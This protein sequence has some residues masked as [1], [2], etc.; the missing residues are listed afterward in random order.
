[1]CPAAADDDTTVVVAVTVAVAAYVADGP[2][3]DV[4]PQVGAAVV[5]DSGVGA[6]LAPTLALKDEE[7]EE[8]DAMGVGR[9]V[10]AIGAVRAAVVRVWLAVT[11]MAVPK[12]T[13]HTL[14]CST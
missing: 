4:V 1:M 9:V 14:A 10:G 5:R 6:A 2:V 11:S 7:E 3:R 12:R 8:E 13:L